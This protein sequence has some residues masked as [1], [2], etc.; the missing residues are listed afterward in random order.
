MLPWMGCHCFLGW[1]ASVRCV[2]VYRSAVVRCRYRGE[3]FRW[4]QEGARHQQ[5]AQTPLPRR[6]PGAHGRQR[7]PFAPGVPC[8]AVGAAWQLQYRASLNAS[9][10]TKGTPRRQRMQRLAGNA[11]N[12]LRR[13]SMP[14][15]ALPACRRKAPCV[16]HC[17]EAA[18]DTGQL[19]SRAYAVSPTPAC[20][21]AI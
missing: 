14:V 5:G 11:P 3:A 18:Q 12:A 8:V 10:A 4:L 16:G 2:A 1:S 9:P 13:G 17:G 20:S 7:H 21:I 19:G 15:P 6:T